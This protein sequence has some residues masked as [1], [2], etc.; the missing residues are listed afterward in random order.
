MPTKYFLP[1]RP[2]FDGCGLLVIL[3]R[4]S[5]LAP[6]IRN[7]KLAMAPSCVSLM[8]HCPCEHGWG[9]AEGNGICKGV[10]FASEIACSSSHSGDAPIQPIEQHREADRLGGVIEVPKFCRSRMHHFEDG[11]VAK[12]HICRGKQRGEDVHPFTEAAP[13]LGWRLIHQRIL[14][15][16]MVLAP[17]SDL[18]EGRYA[19]T[20]E[21]P[22]TRSPTFT[23]G[24][25]EASSWTSQRE[26]NLMRPMR[27]P[28]STRSPILGLNTMRRASSPAICLKT[29]RFP[30]PSTVTTFCSFC[31]ADATS[32][33]FM[34]LP[35]W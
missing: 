21:P 32:M 8:C 3:K 11:V 27:W 7:R 20:L 2:G 25:A 28:R 1:G 26:P 12:R 15:E 30:S 29:T 22:F 9:Y 17:A 5:R 16:A 24:R 35:R 34:N 33:A 31:S 4:A 23:F 6:A 13:R 14:S 10:K 18:C 19:S